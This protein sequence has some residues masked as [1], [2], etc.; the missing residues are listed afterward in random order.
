MNPDKDKKLISPEEWETKR[1]KSTITRDQVNRIVMDYLYTTGCLEAAES[2]SKETRVELVEDSNLEKR[3]SI[4]K[5]ILS[6]EIDTAI[7]LV[8]EIDQK[9]FENNQ[10]LLFKLRLQKLVC[11]I[12]ENKVIE[13]LAYGQEILAP[14]AKGNEELMSELEKALSLI[15]FGCVENSPIGELVSPLYKLKVSNDVNE[16]I[17][18][19][20]GRGKNLVSVA[21]KELKWIEK[22]VG[23]SVNFPHCKFS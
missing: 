11:Y 19:L 10:K 14:S 23:K 16:E 6:D 21:I 22:R 18:K 15:A 20:Q 12:K 4:R 2:F 3:D 17:L 5:A 13:A 9:V 1:N 8:N 7:K